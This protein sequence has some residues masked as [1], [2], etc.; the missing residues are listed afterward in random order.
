MAKKLHP[1]DAS[2]IEKIGT[3]THF[4]AHLR[5][6]PADKITKRAKTLAAAIKAADKLG[7]TQSGKRPLIYAITPDK[8]SILVPAAM[9]AQARKGGAT[10]GRGGPEKRAKAPSAS[11]AAEKP[12][13]KRAAILE[14]A[15]RGEMPDAPDF[16]A[17]THKRFRGKLAQLVAL[18]EA[19]DAAGLK[20]IEIKPYSSSPKAMAR[21]RDLAVLAIEARVAR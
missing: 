8:Q 7:K 1:A 12:A 11:S 13:G 19:G 9:I 21:Y 14:A 10:A 18:A 20:A 5:T 3:A 16:S 4:T 2:A 15:Q 6:G 17:E